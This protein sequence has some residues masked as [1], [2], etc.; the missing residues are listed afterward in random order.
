MA[1]VVAFFFCKNV[2]ISRGRLHDQFNPSNSLKKASFS[3][4]MG[5]GGGG[6]GGGGWVIIVVIL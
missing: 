1:G 5:W 6:G 2:D 4:A 3:F